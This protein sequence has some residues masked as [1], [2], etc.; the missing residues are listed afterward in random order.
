MSNEPIWYT[1]QN[2]RQ[3]RQNSENHDKTYC[4]N[5]NKP[6]TTKYNPLCPVC[7]KK[8][9]TRG[10]ENYLLRFGTIGNATIPYQQYLHRS[11]FGNNV[12]IEYRGLKENRIKAKVTKH[13]LDIAVL[14]LERMI[15]TLSN[16]HSRLYF[17]VHQ[18]KRNIP[19]RIIYNLVLHYILY[20]I[21]DSDIY[22]SEAQFMATVC[23]NFHIQIERLFI[24]LKPDT[25][26][27]KHIKSVRQNYTFKYY[28]KLI[29]EIDKILEP[30]MVEIASSK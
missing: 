23:R 18:L 17:E 12:P 1:E 29:G 9:K 6:L 21:E 27:V 7:N 30:L 11:F 16:E 8:L 20:Y 15:R 4:D 28:K 25:K 24:R 22:K 13:T 26:R 14:K 2:K 5:C 10:L 19:K 3:F